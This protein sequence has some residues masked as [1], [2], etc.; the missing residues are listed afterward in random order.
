MAKSLDKRKRHVE[1]LAT[2]ATTTTRREGMSK[3]SPGSVSPVCTWR[4]PGIKLPHFF[5]KSLNKIIDLKILFLFFFHG[6]CYK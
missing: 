2:A 6:S 4:K 1:T 3:D 5:K